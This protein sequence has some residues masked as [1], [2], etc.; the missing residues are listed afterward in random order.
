MKKF[1]LLAALFISSAYAQEDSVGFFYK[2]DKVIVLINERVEVGTRLSDFI[3]L[4]SSDD[5]YSVTTQDKSIA[6]RCGRVNIGSGC[7]MQFIPGK[8]VQIKDRSLIVNTTVQELG[9]PNVGAFEMSFASSMKDK[10]KLVITNDG[11]VYMEGS[12][13]LSSSL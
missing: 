1:A 12:K 2:K 8:N 13:K 11:K 5:V 6:I 9:L 3:S 7:T 4:V 10:F